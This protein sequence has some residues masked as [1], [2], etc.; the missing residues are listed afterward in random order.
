M[1]VLRKNII[2]C[3]YSDKWPQLF[4][5]VVILISKPSSYVSNQ[6]AMMEIGELLIDFTKD[7]AWSAFA[8]HEVFKQNRIDWFWNEPIMAYRTH[9][10]YTLYTLGIR[11][12]ATRCRKCA[13]C[14][15]ERRH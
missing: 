2:P 7:G 6:Q 15:R 9:V 8:T 1:D 14:L 12:A 13:R 3:A 10:I 11:N 4:E 5:E